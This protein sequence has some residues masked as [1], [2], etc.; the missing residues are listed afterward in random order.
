M[1]IC[2]LKISLPVKSGDDMKRLLLSLLFLV[3]LLTSLQTELLQ[4]S[5]VWILQTDTNESEAFRRQALNPDTMEALRKESQGDMERFAELLT[6]AML[7]SRF[8]EEKMDGSLVFPEEEFYRKY[9]DTAYQSLLESYKAIWAD[10]VYFPVAAADTS[11]A[12]TWGEPRTYGGDR[13][14]EGTDIFGS[15]DVSGYYPIVSM[16]EGVVE[17]VGWL[18]LGGY[19]IGIRSPHGG[20]FYYCHL[21]SYD[22]EFRHGDL[23]A[24]GEILGFMG[25][26]GYGEEGTRGKF[27]VHLHLGIYITTSGNPELSVNPYWIL[28][29]MEEQRIVFVEG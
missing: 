3:C 18:P 21:S 13:L 1:M 17:Q 28:R 15:Q 19:R 2:T 8:S 11:F 12:D 16:T 5:Q 24:A 9:K 14:H 23:V 6:N 27:P 7:R 29:T 10:L 4:R 26:T 22:R 20:Y 25:N